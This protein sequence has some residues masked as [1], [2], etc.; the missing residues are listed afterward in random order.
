LNST[1][2]FVCLTQAANAYFSFVPFQFYERVSKL[3]T[4]ENKLIRAEHTN[5]HGN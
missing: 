5:L 2:S 1:A 4:F 3:L